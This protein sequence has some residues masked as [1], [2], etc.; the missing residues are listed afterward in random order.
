MKNLEKSTNHLQTAEETVMQISV[1]GIK[2][3]EAFIAELLANYLRNKPTTN[4]PTVS[5]AFQ[6]YMR[7]RTGRKGQRFVADATRN[8][9][10]FISQFGDMP[11]RDL[12]HMH[13]A[14]FRDAQLAK[15]L[16]PVS[17]RKQFATLNAMLNVSFK[18]LD[19]DRL[20]PF[21]GLYIEGEG[22]TK[23]YMRTI[24]PELLQQ[25]KAMLLKSRTQYKLVALLQLNTGFRLSEPMFALRKDLVLDH[26]IPH[27]WIRRNE[28]SDRKTKSSIRAVP[29]VGASYDAAVELNNISRWYDSPW[30]VPQYARE[31]GNASCSAI[32]NKYLK[33]LEFRSHMFRHA[34]V[35]RLK[36][37]NDVPTRLAES[38]TGHSSGGSDFNI[39]GTVGYT[40]EQK[41]EVLRRVEV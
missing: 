4:E 33:D 34:L 1:N 17:V 12:R 16:N 23:R 37:C 5:T 19:I 40:L 32:I 28:L 11:L 7:E 39:Y 24:T 30:L 27:L 6:I 21:R 41:L 38:I 20:S 10:Y 2:F 8:C 35:D 3:D 31:N 36:A 9:N 25:V 26:E 22:E 29:L 18:Y 15:G 14:Q 13:G